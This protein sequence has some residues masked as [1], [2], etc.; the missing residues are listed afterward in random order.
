MFVSYARADASDFAEYMVAALQAAGFDAY[1]DRHDIAKA[2]DWEKRLRELIAKS[3]TVVFI[4]SPASIKSTRCDWEVKRTIELGKR[5]IPVQWIKVPEADV[6]VELKS[7]NYTIFESGAPFGVPMAELTDTLRQDLGWLRQRTHLG[8]EAERWQAR[9][10]D[11]DLL[12]RG[13][14]LTEARDWVKRR[15][16]DAPEVSPLLT[17]F[18]GASEEALA[19]RQTKESK[20]LDERRKL[21]DKAEVAQKSRARAV[22]WIGALVVAMLGVTVWLSTKTA[23]REARLLL[24]KAQEALKNGQ[25]ERAMQYSLASLPPS[26]ALLASAPPD[27]EVE[28]ARAAY[29][30]RLITRL[31]GEDAVFEV[32]T[33]SPDG[34]KIL[35]RT[36]G[37][38]EA[39]LWNAETGE[40][41]RKL[42]G[43]TAEI[44]YAAFVGDTNIVRTRG[45]DNTVRI[46]DALTG[47]EKARI[48]TGETLIGFFTS[49]D[50]GRLASWAE[51]QPL[52]IW[53]LVAQRQIVKIDQKRVPKGTYF[54]SPDGNRVVTS[55]PVKENLVSIQLWNA[56][57]AEPIGPA[58]DFKYPSVVFNAVGD[59]LRISGDR[60][61]GRANLLLNAT[62][63]SPLADINR[64]LTSN[65]SQDGSRL[66]VYGGANA[67]VRVWDARTGQPT[68]HLK[69]HTGR[70]QSSISNK[71]GNRIVTL[72]SDRTARLWDA[73][74]GEQIGPSLSL[75][76]EMHTVRFDPQE[77]FV[78]VSGAGRSV[79]IWQPG[80]ELS[81]RIDTI[82]EGPS[83]SFSKD[84]KKLTTSKQHDE[85]VAVWD[86]ETGAPL[87][88]L[89]SP[90]NPAVSLS[91]DGRRILTRDDVSR[92]VRLWQIDTPQRRWQE[93]GQEPDYR[94][95]FTNA[96]S[97][98]LTTGEDQ[99]LRVWN[100]VE[101]REVASLPGTANSS[102]LAMNSA[103]T[104]I[105][106]SAKEGIT[107][108]DVAMAKPIAQLGSPASGWYSGASFD[109]DG[110]RLLLNRVN[111]DSGSVGTATTLSFWDVRAKLLIWEKRIEEI[112]NSATLNASGD[113]IAYA[114]KDK[115][116]VVLNGSGEVV[117][118]STV[119]PVAS[120]TRLLFNGD[121]SRLL[122]SGSH[123]EAILFDI[124]TLEVVTK[125]LAGP[126]RA[127]AR[128]SF[129]R[130][131][132]MVLTSTD[133]DRMV[134]IWATSSG[135]Q[136]GKD[137]KHESD[138]QDASLSTDGRSV[139]TALRNGNLLVWDVATGK[140][141]VSIDGAHT[142]KDQ[143]LDT[144]YAA[145]NHDATEVFSIAADKAIRVWDIKVAMMRGASLRSWVCGVA[146]KGTQKFSD[147]EMKDP[148][149]RGDENLRN[150]CDRHGMGSWEYWKRLPRGLSRL[151]L[152]IATAKQ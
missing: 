20:D 26:G 87:A 110:A 151:I 63:G 77:R 123:N 97:F 6:P 81:R 19:A 58:S 17:A 51:G 4:I 89:F 95:G 135:K 41:L 80:T 119:L 100:V 21:V 34:K 121:D 38:T 61:G 36:K 10:R 66:I 126:P 45:D 22:R 69:G 113:R 144:F 7:R 134:R 16:S 14:A 107:V 136:I 85:F 130:D 59:R 86:I 82:R 83:L 70:V 15:K 29:R 65:F 32:A 92:A 28:L 146:L 71:D 25:Y 62:D 143:R 12:L 101:H 125:Y 88:G 91:A 133:D 72:G 42:S 11:A 149:I 94:I 44:K 142:T 60:A 109:S 76:P 56:N 106:T 98:V 54:F 152:G 3:D 8:E 114:S 116:I 30:S 74:S 75:E 53:D 9:G 141:V 52:I 67:V 78:V 79:Q 55:T 131:D 39:V 150:P 73:M 128:A 115:S 137:M 118:R 5:L 102:F 35:T 24:S 127:F 112:V 68:V 43:H 46:W 2:E 132:N 37:D 23:D 129:S 104:R 13:A 140:T 27:S 117:A 148:I 1:L 124:A 111:D 147:T 145:F 138:I 96:N 105:A 57:T 122:W 90:G 103:G 99:L 48:G 120:A 64:Y 139:V 108:W 33:F 47:V 50:G 18:I 49:R 31:G 93:L 40:R 84:G